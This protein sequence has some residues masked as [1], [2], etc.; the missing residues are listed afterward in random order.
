MAPKTNVDKLTLTIDF[1][2]DENFRTALAE[3]L[4]ISDGEEITDEMIQKRK[5]MN[6]SGKNISDFTGIEYFTALT[7]LNCSENRLT[8][9]DVSKNTALTRLYCHNN[10]LTTL[11]VSNN[12]ALTS[13]LCFSNQIKGKA[14]DALVA[15]LPTVSENWCSFYVIDTKDANEGNVCTKS[16]VAVAKEKGWAVYAWSDSWQKYDG[17]E[18]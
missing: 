5:I 17:S 15:S 8:S 11:D 12:T 9:L 3:I 13:S 16:Q 14:M 2:S 18:D 4:G 7:T 10:Q 6:V 1:F